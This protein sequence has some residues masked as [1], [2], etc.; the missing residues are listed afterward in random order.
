MLNPYFSLTRLDIGH[1]TSSP[2]AV[3]RTDQIGFLQ[4]QGSGPAAPVRAANMRFLIPRCFITVCDTPGRG[5]HSLHAPAC[6]R[7]ANFDART[8]P[9]GDSASGRY[10]STGVITHVHQTSLNTNFC[11]VR[12][13][14][15]DWFV[16]SCACT[17][18]HRHVHST[19]K[20]FMVVFLC[21]AYD[22]VQ[23]TRSRIARGTYIC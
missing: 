19:V 18:H 5:F 23:E 11:V 14:A 12:C 21:I 20:M 2:S 10:S 6:S 13:R 9:K 22:L 4:A 7:S 15:R 8:R 1:S 16:L 3:S 17:V